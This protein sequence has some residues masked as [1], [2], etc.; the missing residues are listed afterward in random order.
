MNLLERFWCWTGRHE[1]SEEAE[2]RLIDELHRCLKED[3]CFYL[4]GLG[5]IRV[6]TKCQ[7]CGYN[8]K[9]EAADADGLEYYIRE[10]D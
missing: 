5:R 8:L 9:I 6:D 7:R 3:A 10:I 4:H 1:I 2:E